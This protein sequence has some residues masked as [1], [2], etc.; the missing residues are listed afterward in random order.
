MN[1]NDV[2]IA[3]RGHCATPANAALVSPSQPNRLSDSSTVQ[4][5]HTSANPRLEKFLTDHGDNT[6]SGAVRVRL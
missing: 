1:P 2:K 5:R 3:V 4:P 6:G